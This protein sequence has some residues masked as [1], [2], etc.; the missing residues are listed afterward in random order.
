MQ[1]WLNVASKLER[2]TA[3]PVLQ[4]QED[5]SERFN[6]EMIIIIIN[7][8]HNI[9]ILSL[10]LIYYGMESLKFLDFTEYV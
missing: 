6:G 1:H 2:A 3:A 10:Y 4:K 9:M 7:E 5:Q 8:G